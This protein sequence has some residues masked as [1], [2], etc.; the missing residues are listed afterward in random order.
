MISCMRWGAE[1]QMVQMDR[2]HR[3]NRREWR[4]GWGLR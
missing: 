2:R 1:V 4:Y 3:R